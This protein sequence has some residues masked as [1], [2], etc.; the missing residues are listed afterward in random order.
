M[1]CLIIVAGVA[2]A[3]CSLLFTKKQKDDVQM[4]NNLIIRVRNKI[5]KILKLSKKNNFFKQ[6][7]YFEVNN[8]KIWSDLSNMKLFKDNIDSAQQ[9]HREHGVDAEMDTGTPINA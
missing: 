7:N 8:I 2:A 6:L 3:S 4:T 9:G 5:Q 1:Q